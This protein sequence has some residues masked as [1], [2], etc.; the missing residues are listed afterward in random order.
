MVLHARKE[1][2]TKWTGFH[3][4]PRCPKTVFTTY[5]INAERT[6]SNH[7]GHVAL[8]GGLEGTSFGKNVSV[9]PYCGQFASASE[10]AGT[11]RLT[12]EEIAGERR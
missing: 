6:K 11:G 4:R 7:R 12:A 5:A 9:R 8:W 10:A 1:G 3:R 2:K